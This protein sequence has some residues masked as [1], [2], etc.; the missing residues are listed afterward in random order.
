M[1]SAPPVPAPAIPAAA[2]GMAEREGRGGGGWTVRII[3][4]V[5]VVLWLIPALGV[6]ITS[7]RPEALADSTGWWTA[8]ARPFDS[9]QWTMDNYSL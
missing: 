9:A 2:R 7:F 5:I 6:L 1:S 3:V 8:L 4:L